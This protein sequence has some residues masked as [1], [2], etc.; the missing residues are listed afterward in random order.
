[1]VNSKGVSS[2]HIKEVDMKV[3]KRGEKRRIKSKSQMGRTGKK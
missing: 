3:Q 1:M 2:L